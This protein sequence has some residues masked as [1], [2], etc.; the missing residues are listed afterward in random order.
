MDQS[1]QAQNWLEAKHELHNHRLLTGHVPATIVTHLPFE[2][3]SLTILRDPVERTISHYFFLRSRGHLPLTK[4]NKPIEIEEFVDH[5]GTRGVAYNFQ[6]F[7]LAVEIDSVGNY[8]DPLSAY[9]PRK[10][11]ENLQA[12]TV[13]G[14]TENLDLTMSLLHCKLGWD[15]PDPLAT[16]NP[17]V[18]FAARNRLKAS[19]IKAIRNANLCDIEV[20]EYARQRLRGDVGDILLRA[21]ATE[22]KRGV[23][24]SSTL[25]KRT[26]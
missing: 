8:A 10:A 1:A 14:T 9:D 23:T 7:Q 26:G 17:T 11:I 18:P 2:T 24:R 25:H 6:T 15:G 22:S 12:M 13:V 16:L 5:P 3:T 4:Q 20:Y 21:T 19:T